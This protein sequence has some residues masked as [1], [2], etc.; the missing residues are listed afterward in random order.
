MKRLTLVS[1][2]VAALLIAPS[3]FAK[4]MSGRFGLGYDTTMGGVNGLSVRYQTAKTFG[5]QAV[6]GF[7]FASSTAVQ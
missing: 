2:I 7:D 1:L 3:A 4:D 5:I 6:L